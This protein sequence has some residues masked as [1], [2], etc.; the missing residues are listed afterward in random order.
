MAIIKPTAGTKTSLTAT[1]LGT[2]ASATYV[3][4]STY[5]AGTGSPLDVVVEA[6]IGTTNT[7][8]G[9]KQVL[10]FAQASFDSGTTWQS[11]PTS[12]TTATDEADLTLL[13]VVPV[14]QSGTHVKSFSVASAF[15][16]YVPPAF[17]VIVKNDLGVA[18]TSGSLATVEYAGN[19]A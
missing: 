9:N 12:G 3:A 1:G 13:G 7:P 16:G 5:N 4:S 19:V 14:S 8:T 15:G 11:G 2:L 6:V 18:L 10:V 17:R